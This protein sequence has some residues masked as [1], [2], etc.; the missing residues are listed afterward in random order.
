VSRETFAGDV[1]LAAR[2]LARSDQ[3]AR[4]AAP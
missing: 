1:S 4:D 3:P 2:W